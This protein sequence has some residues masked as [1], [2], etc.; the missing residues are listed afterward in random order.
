M[1]KPNPIQGASP[2]ASLVF[3][4]C[5]EFEAAITTA[6]VHFC[7]FRPG[8]FAGGLV[9][10]EL[11]GA[12]FQAG[13]H[14]VGQLCCASGHPQMAHL[15]FALDSE[16][17]ISCNGHPMHDGAVALYRP[18]A[19]HFSYS[20]GGA[21]WVSLAVESRVLTQTIAALSGAEAWEFPENCKIFRPSPPTLQ[22]LRSV[23]DRV[24]SAVDCESPAFQS[25]AGRRAV[26]Q[27]LVT[28]IAQAVTERGCSPATRSASMAHTQL[29]RSA[30][31]FFRENLGRPIYIAELAAATRASER[32]LRKVFR[33]FYGMS[34]VRYL[35]LLRMNQVRRALRVA[36]PQTASVTGV[37]AQCGYW[38]MG[39]F[40]VQYKAL[41]GEMPSQTLRSPA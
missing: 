12:V 14:N 6:N 35:S 10:V 5:E 40:A 24:H 28:A 9:R 13:H 36:D 16:H 2:V 33:E 1:S 18:G 37:A 21:K 3:R 23:I 15:V 19:E 38:D 20:K 26:E 17:E 41:F 31:D 39:R 25:D 32:T 11:P 30:H 4:S 27:S 22:H 29:V 7:Q 8:R 34:P